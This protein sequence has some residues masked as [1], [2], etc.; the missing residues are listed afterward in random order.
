[1]IIYN[2]LKYKGL[3]GWQKRTL[4]QAIDVFVKPTETPVEPP[5]EEPKKK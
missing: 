4:K 1:M 5:V 2:R 3:S